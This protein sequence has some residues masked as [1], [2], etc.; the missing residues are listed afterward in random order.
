[1]ICADRVVAIT[2]AARGIGL[3]HAEEF[4]RQ[5]AH[6]VV[7]DVDGGDHTTDVS[8][9]DG[10]KSLVDLAVSRHGRLDV[11]VNNAG[12]VRDRMLVSTSE[13]EWDDVVRV[14]LKAHFLTMRHAAEHWRARSKAGEAV[15]ARVINTS[16]GAGLF[17]SVGQANYSAAKAG[18]VGLTLV[19]AAELA[20]Y[21]VTVNAIA[22]SARTRM[23]EDLFPGLPGPEDIAPLVVWLGSTASAGVTGRVFEVAA[24]KITVVG[25]HQRVATVD[26]GSRWP[27]EEVGAAVAELIAR[28]PPE[29]P[30]YG[31]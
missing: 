16:S 27:A 25:G 18:I 4:R 10:A 30:V 12:V 11:L 23:T 24:G 6:V 28:T 2:G 9:W 13:Q 15:S 21:G 1:M 20:R 14:H 17:G 8:T 5:G 19:A 31:A 29:V 22:P 3:A 7:N 26:R